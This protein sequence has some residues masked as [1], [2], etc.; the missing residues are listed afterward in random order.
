[1]HLASVDALAE[2]FLEVSD[3]SFV[4]LVDIVNAVFVFEL[5]EA[6]RRY[7]CRE[8]VRAGQLGVKRIHG[9]PFGSHPTVYPRVRVVPM[10]WTHALWLCQR[11][12]EKMVADAWLAAD[13]RLSDRRP[14]PCS[15]STNTPTH[16]QH[17]GN[18]ASLCTCQKQV[19]HNVSSVVKLMNDIGLSTHDESE[20]GP[21]Q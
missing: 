16:L 13:Q 12:R 6:L 10:G 4:K 20:R 7:I 14:C 18:F 21:L 17:V 2:I 3:E 5:P 8:G 9:V 11:L 1:M 15:S 19:S